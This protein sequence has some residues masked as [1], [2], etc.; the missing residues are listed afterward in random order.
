MEE[1]FLHSFYEFFFTFLPVPFFV[2]G[3]DILAALLSGF[4]ALFGID[5]K[6]IGF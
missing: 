4:Y 5:V 6:I 2:Q 1:S 3:V